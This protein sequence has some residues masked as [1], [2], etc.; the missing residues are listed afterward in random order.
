MG[1][2]SCATAKIEYPLRWR[3]I[4]LEPLNSMN[5]DVDPAIEFKILRPIFAG[6][7]DLVAC[8]YLLKLFAIDRFEDPGAIE[9]GAALLARTV[10]MLSRAF[11]GL[12]A[13]EFF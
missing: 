2:V 10:E 12:A 13:Q 7:F 5:V 6:M 3:D 11:E 8:P 1:E 9:R 4:E